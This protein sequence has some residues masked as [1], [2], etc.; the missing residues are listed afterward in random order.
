[1]ETTEIKTDVT[2]E[3]SLTLA[4]NQDASRYATGCVQISP[5]D[6]GCYLAA[7]DCKQATIVESDGQTDETRLIPGDVLPTRMHPAQVTLNGVWESSHG[8]V[9]KDDDFG[10]FPDIAK[11]LPSFYDGDGAFTLGLTGD[12]L[13]AIANALH[14][15]GMI[16]LII[17]KPKQSG[18]DKGQVTGSIGVLGS[19]GFGVIM[20]MLTQDRE[21]PPI[22]EYAEKRAAY[23]ASRNENADS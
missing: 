18:P 7:T 2:I 1:M 20:P 19:R 23:I 3:K 21:V 8:K 15:H 9:A 6:G 16:T 13:A 22:E 10:R 11:V 5:R 17:P 4:T 14:E 12:N